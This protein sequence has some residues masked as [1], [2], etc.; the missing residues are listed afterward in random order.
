MDML[1]LLGIIALFAVIPKSVNWLCA[2][3]KCLRLLGASLLCFVIGICLSFVLPKETPSSA[4]SDWCVYLSI[5][6]LLFG[7]NVR[8]LRKL[9][10]PAVI[11]FILI[12]LCVVAVSVGGHYLFRDAL[13]GES[14]IVNGTLVGLFVG[15][16]INMGAVGSGLGI[17][18]NTLTMLNTAYIVAGTAY[19]VIAAVVLPPIARRFLPKY[20]GTDAAAAQLQQS[21][22]DSMQSDKQHL[23]W[24]T[25]WQ[26]GLLMVL[27]VAIVFVS[28]GISYV[29][30]GNAQDAIVQMLCITTLSLAC[31]LIPQIQHIKGSYAIGEYL[32]NMFC[33]AMGSMFNLSGES[34]AG[35]LVYMLLML[36]LQVAAAVLHLLL[37]KLFRI[38]ADTALI[39]SAAAIFSP[40]FIP[41]I[42]QFMKNRDLV[43]VGLVFSILGF[44]VANY[45]GFAAYA[46]LALA[47]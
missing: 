10:K 19:L 4:V 33:V 12:C 44:I 45:A 3:I 35:P 31:A 9:A 23:S 20:R 21:F 34:N 6:F 24:H 38:D 16:L 30:T 17:N 26:K 39:T 28:M 47:G 43:A 40:A 37:A 14:E 22:S 25:V 15:G 42:A 18:G 7:L 2:H 1:L 41:P 29:T 8:D 13:G 5:P 27:A 11:S 36:F 32:I 46:L